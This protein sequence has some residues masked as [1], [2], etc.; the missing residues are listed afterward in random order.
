MRACVR[1]CDFRYTCNNATKQCEACN[2]TYCTNDSQCPGSYCMIHGPGPWQ[3]HDAPA[4][5][6]GNL[7]ACNASCAHNHTT[8]LYVCNPFSGQCVATTNSTPGATT[9]YIC[10]HNCT[11]I[12][13][14]GTWR[15][16]EVNVGFVRGEWDF[17]FYNDSTLHWRRPD[18][19]TFMAK[20]DGLNMSAGLDNTIQ[21][22]GVVDTSPAQDIF[23]V[24]RIDNQGNDKIVDMLF[25]GQSNSS[26]PADFPSAMTN[27][28]TMHILNACRGSA[29]NCDFSK[30]AVFP[31]EDTQIVP[32]QVKQ[33]TEVER[34]ERMLYSGGLA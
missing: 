32:V 11:S 23:A 13:P 21:I 15:G 24:F 30:S 14:L 28:N 2:M 27:G 4:S 31:T 6:C 17:T 3:C 8:E 9:K 19:A 12:A 5:N 25:W 29:S 7:P 33:L 34:F 26:F 22:S 10:E 20:L 18:G 1:A 16:V